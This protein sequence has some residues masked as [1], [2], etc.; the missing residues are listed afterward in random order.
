MC[1]TSRERSL[2]NTAQKSVGNRGLYLTEAKRSILENKLKSA[3]E[4]EMSEAITKYFKLDYEGSFMHLERAHIL[5]QSFIAPH[6]SSHWWM[7]KIGIRRRDMKEIFG[8]MTR[9]IAS[10]LFSKIWIP[11]GNTGGANV[12]PFKPMPIPSDLKKFLEGEEA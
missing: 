11:I 3:F 6:V 2:N 10:M 7:L 1:N 9:I 8:Q 4:A 5:G 12:S